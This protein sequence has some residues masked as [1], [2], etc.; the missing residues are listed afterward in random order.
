MLK[1]LN[2]IQ[3]VCVMVFTFSFGYWLFS[4]DHSLFDIIDDYYFW[5]GKTEQTISFVISIVSVVGF[6]LFKDKK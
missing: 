6:F 4:P 2:T 1:N 3:K 5:F